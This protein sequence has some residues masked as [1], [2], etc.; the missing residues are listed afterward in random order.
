MREKIGIIPGID[1]L[2]FN[3]GNFFGD[4]VSISLLGTNGTELEAAVE[5]L[6]LELTKIKDLTDIQDS[7]EEGLKEIILDL[8]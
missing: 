6:K 5:E 8:K 3:L 1:K 7:N 2:V 4:P